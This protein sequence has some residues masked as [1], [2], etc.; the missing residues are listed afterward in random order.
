MSEQNVKS[1]SSS[2]KRSGWGKKLLCVF[3][4]LVLLVVI[5]FFVVTSGAFLKG[6]ILPKVGA[7][8]NADI[9]AGDVALSPFSQLELHDLKVT[10]KGKETLLTTAL[11]RVRYSLFSIIGG[12]IIVPEV[13]IESP[14]VTLVTEADGSSNLDPITKQASAQSKPAPSSSKSSAPP[15]IDIKSVALKNATVRT[16]KNFKDGTHQVIELSNVNFSLADLKNGATG[17]MEVSAAIAMDDTVT[18]TVGSLMAKLNGSFTFD[19]TQDLKPG[20]VNGKLSLAVNE[21]KGGLAQLAALT[22]DVDCE[23]TPT[24][25]KQMSLKFAQSGQALGEVRVSG[26]FDAAKSEGKLTVSVL[27]ID[28]RVLN[29]AGAASGMDFGTTMINSTNVIELTK[30]GAVI[31][32]SGQLD[33]AHARVTTKAGQTTPTLDLRVDYAVT[34][35]N[36][37]KT[38]LLQKL[39]IAGQQDSK[40][41]LQGALTSPMMV[42][43]GGAAGTMGDAAFNLTVNDLSLDPWRAFAADMAP[44]GMVNVKLKVLSQ[45]GGKTMVFDLDSGVTGLGA[46]VNDQTISGVGVAVKAHGTAAS[47]GAA[48]LNQIKLDSYTLDVTQQ[49]QS[50]LAVSGSGTVDSATQDADLQLTVQAALARLL[51]IVPQPGLTVD[52]GT[53]D[54]KGHVTKKQQ[55]QA[56]N[57]KIVLAG[58]TGKSGNNK[59]SNLGATVDLDAGAKGQQMEVR[60]GMLTL[61]PTERAK[62]EIRLTGTIDMTKPTAISGNL[63][64]ASDAVDVTHFYDVMEGNTN[65]ASAP[66]VKAQAQASDN[67]KEPDAVK[68]PVGNFVFEINVGHFYLREV[69]AANF[70]M[71]TKIEGSHVVIKPAQLTLNAAPINGSV[72]LNLGVPGYVYDVNFT[73]DKIPLAPL[74]NSFAPDRK[75]QISGFTTAGAQIKGAGVT[76][77]SLQKNLAGQFNFLSTNMNLSLTNV[78]SP[79]IT[80]VIN[81]VVGLPDLI[82]NPTAILGN[83]LNKGKST[84][85]Q[86]T[87]FT[88][89][90][91]AAPIDV[92]LVNAQAANGK[93]QLQQTEVRSKAFQI[94]AKGEI[95]IAPIL[96]NSTIQIPVSVTLSRDLAGK[97][98]LVTKDTPTNGVY[99]PLPDFLKLKGTV[100]K[101]G[102]D[103]DAMALL[104]FA[105]KTAGGVGGQTGG[106]AKDKASSLI[107]AASGLFG[108]KK[109]TPA[110]AKDQKKP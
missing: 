95:A 105:A 46:K 86:N 58:L 101:P 50:A 28:K 7:S 35:D 29:L 2:P 36:A 107:D 11:V 80:S 97:L 21:A 47:T 94:L 79:M 84:G 68:L 12:K 44:A 109:S 14:V 91:T 99:V 98:G 19:L 69:E 24:E 23:A 6:V 40:S 72:D 56:V 30:G 48:S 83:L 45:Q 75:G 66:V 73:A 87:G 61:T 57:A 43:F 104:S 85:T 96:T 82:R 77:T 110:P 17:K 90:L 76:G 54:F 93:V 41:F 108:G 42:S 59:F 25:I 100:G 33:A 103:I 89:Q 62:N 5:L 70:Q 39:D 1:S 49:G 20:K 74:V 65:A 4:V 71:I 88:D 51:A 26:P 55:D 16:T 18:N 53:V 67:N 31:M 22:A 10:P 92:M 15:T 38:A 60:T 8:M 9:T 52:S 27:S 37:A 34:V 78:K 106:A 64:L 63:K 13:T 81:T 32:A 3:G 102:K